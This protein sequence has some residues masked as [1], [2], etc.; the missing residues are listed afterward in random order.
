MHALWKKHLN[1]VV[2]PWES[3]RVVHTCISCFSSTGMCGTRKLT[4][5]GANP[6]S[7]HPHPS[8]AWCCQ[9]E[10]LGRLG[11]KTGC[12]AMPGCWIELC[13]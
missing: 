7:R 2:P 9:A 6:S 5:A 1:N 11:S 8:V 12:D 3:K 13:I 10:R 4:T